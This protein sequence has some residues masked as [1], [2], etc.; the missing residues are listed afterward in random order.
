ME[1]FCMLFTQN[2]ESHSGL[3]MFL[4]SMTTIFAISIPTKLAYNLLMN[5]E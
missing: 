2:G 4:I 1:V 3:K 5:N